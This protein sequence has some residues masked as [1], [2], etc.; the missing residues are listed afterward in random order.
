MDQSRS[1]VEVWGLPEDL[2]EH[3][4]VQKV[5]RY[6][7]KCEPGGGEVVKVLYPC[8]GPG[9]A[10]IMFKEPEAAARVLQK[11]S[12]VLRVNHQTYHVKVK[13]PDSPEVDLP[14]EAT[15]HLN[16]FSD[17][18][19]VREI[20]LS[21]DFEMKMVDRNRLQI[22]GSF[23][24]L[25]AAKIRLEMLLHSQKQNETPPSPSK[26]RSQSGASSSYPQ[27]PRSE[28]FVID[29]DVLMYAKRV[30]KQHMEDILR[31]HNVQMEERPSGDNISIT[32]QGKS[33]QTAITK[34]QS[35]LNELSLSLR[36]QEVALKNMDQEGRDLLRRIQ[37]GNNVYKSVLVCR[38]SDT[39]HL[40]GP[41]AESY[42]VKQQLM[43]T[44][45]DR[46]GRTGTTVDQSGRTGTRRSTS[47]PPVN[48]RK[49]D[50]ARDAN[51]KSSPVEARG[52]SLK[53][54]PKHEAAAHSG[55]SEGHRGRSRQ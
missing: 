13:A 19:K 6:F 5:H 49:T 17:Q 11:S 10:F 55:A 54:H 31:R 24:K 7:T 48:G 16:S 33:T 42:E 45:A 47:V 3:K 37:Q 40:I 46:S 1:M 20:L 41:S 32:L 51:L 27:Q 21:H 50:R 22:T 15:V 4:L 52:H 26:D 25:G 53:Y 44:T 8:Y 2:Q 35:F 23:L 28:S 30:M 14:V 9:Q 38:R 43:G 29:M 36:T 39:L 18:K 34:L 12:H